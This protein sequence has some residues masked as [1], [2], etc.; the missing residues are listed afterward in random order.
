MRLAGKN[1]MV[2][3]AGRGIGRA[4]A[5][6][7]AREGAAVVA[8]SL[9]LANA[10]RTAREIAEAGG[11]AIALQ[12]D[13]ARA[14]SVQQMVQ[15]AVERL[16]RIHV[17]VS[18]AGVNSTVP[19]LELTEQEWDRVN[20][21]NSKGHFLVGQAVA[22]HMAGNG[23][24]S[25]IIVASQLS[26]TAIPHKAHYLASKGA[27]KMLAKGMAVDLAR[28][29]IRVNALGP[30]VTLTDMTR[31]RLSD[32][33]IMRWSLERIPMGRLGAPEDMVGAA[34]FLASEES[35]YVTG[36]IV[37]VDGGYLAR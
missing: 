12:V 23:G 10:E 5:L 35:A 2:T 16:G 32:P 13:T 6:G 18:N 25:I 21:V 4:I 26:E 20:G 34:L 37:F 8:A 15:R 17:L 33:E 3:G 27:A 22:R 28:Y 31:E 36:T 29:N 11:R 9:T 19:F 24:G 30:G 14:D 1:V 7:F